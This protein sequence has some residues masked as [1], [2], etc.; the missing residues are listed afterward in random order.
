MNGGGRR[1]GAELGLQEREDDLRTREEMLLQRES[2]LHTREEA[3][4]R[5]ERQFKELWEESLAT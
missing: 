5:K 3:L 1:A 2:D 4:A